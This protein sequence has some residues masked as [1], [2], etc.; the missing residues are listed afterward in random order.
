MLLL[1]TFVQL[2]VGALPIAEQAFF[3]S[4]LCA[5]TNI[6][7]LAGRTNFAHWCD[8]TVSPCQWAGVTCIEDHVIGLVIDG[9]SDP[10]LPV[11]GRLPST[12]EA[13]PELRTLRLKNLAVTGRISTLVRLNTKLFVA[14]F[15]NVPVTGDFS[16]DHFAPSLVT[17]RI[18]NTRVRGTLA[19]GDPTRLSLR[20]LEIV[21]PGFSGALPV[22]LFQLPLLADLRIHDTNINGTIPSQVCTRTYLILD[23]SGNK[24]TD[25]PMCLASLPGTSPCI[26]TGNL[27][28]AP[29]RLEDGRCTVE[30][31]PLG[32]TDRCLVC[33][34]DGLSCIDCAGVAFGTSTPDLCGTCGGSV[35]DINRCPRDCFGEPA[36]RAIYDS[37]DV[38]G[39]DDSVCADCAGFPNG[40]GVYDRCDVCNGDGES[41]VDCRGAARGSAQYD[42][43]DVCGGDSSTCKDCAGVPLGTAFYDVCDVCNGGARR[44][45]DCAGVPFG[46]KA[47]D[48]CDICNGDGSTC[49]LDVLIEGSTIGTSLMIGFG[50]LTLF[51]VP[52]CFLAVLQ[53]R[54]RRAGG[55]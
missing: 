20:A 13:L 29:I 2:V 23:L 25:R 54:V 38:C 51:L 16:F 6:G 1:L 9:T 17:L 39:G 43:C 50:V 5:T 12:F 55:K 52:A 7:T 3:F 37:C 47:Y 11:T 44:C 41:C 26:L 48:R 35:S 30:T 22:V 31:V 15:D 28:C 10:D 33:A 40:P 32:R 49:G 34:G 27:F 18:V 45:S 53:R 14:E 8:R 21:G 19:S 46:T 36:G 42:R 4:Q 24:L